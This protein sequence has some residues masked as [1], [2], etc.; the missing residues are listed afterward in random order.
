MS[1]QKRLHSTYDVMVI[2]QNIVNRCSWSKPVYVSQ[3]CRHQNK[4]VLWDVFTC[5]TSA[6]LAEHNIALPQKEKQLKFLDTMWTTEGGLY[7][8]D[9]QASV[10]YVR[11]PQLLK[12]QFEEEIKPLFLDGE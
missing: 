8:V 7:A 10:Y 1:C 12:W 9:T 5:C 4:L 2:E 6:V 3:I 11:I